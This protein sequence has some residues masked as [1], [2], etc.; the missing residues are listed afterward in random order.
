MA[1]GG[2]I[3]EFLVGLGWKIDTAGQRRFNKG[4]ND[5]GKTVE[6]LGSSLKLITEIL[7]S[8]YEKMGDVTA[9]AYHFRQELNGLNKETDGAARVT[10]RASVSWSEARANIIAY[11]AGA[12]ASV[13]AIVAYTAKT[14]QSYEALEY[15]SQRAQST[16]AGM[17]K[18][19]FA[20]SEMGGNAD[21]ARGSLQAMGNFLR[22]TP[23][24]E[25]FIQRLGVQT[26][27][28]AGAMRDTS[29]IMTDLGKQ[30]RNMPYWRARA[31]AGMLGIDENTLQAMIRGTSD[32][33]SKYAAIYK[34]LGI[35]QN[36]AAKASTRFMQ[37]FRLMGAV[38]T[39]VRDKLAIGLEPVIER[40]I[41]LLYQFEEWV[42]RLDGSTKGWI[43]GIS[44]FIV[45]WLVMNTAI[46]RSPIGRV[47]ALGLAIAALYDDYKT[48]QAG[49]KSL[50]N[51]KEWAPGID[52]AI[53]AISQIK[54][55]LGDMWTDTAPYLKPM[56]DFIKHEMID[57]FLSLGRVVGSVA[58]SIDKMLH[59]NFGGAWSDLK[60][61]YSE[62]QRSG[63][64]A[65]N[66]GGEVAKG[67]LPRGLRNNNPGNIR[68]W[69]GAGSDGQFA[70]FKSPDEGIS[71]AV[72]NIRA[73]INKHGIDTIRG[74]IS[75][76]APSS[77]GNN[78]DAYIQHVSQRTHIDPDAHISPNDAESIGRIVDAITMSENSGLN[79][80]REKDYSIAKAIVGN[81]N[82]ARAATNSASAFSGA[83][84]SDAEADALRNTYTGSQSSA[85]TVNQTVT[86]NGATNPQSVADSVVRVTHGAVN[87]AYR[88]FAPRRQ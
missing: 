37:Q 8:M 50:I 48:W 7:I 5:A 33:G 20:I 53:D 73:Y 39:A 6:G 57:A 79:P 43:A 81:S 15:A 21:A 24:G 87:T 35:D 27:D 51:W 65:I 31:S 1:D 88:N 36:Q 11:A 29:S 9:E 34:R 64:E 85:P 69:A 54:T 63:Q 28:A 25:G 14:A 70:V 62:L 17:Q 3:K 45:V 12:A 55:L 56:A 46:M 71:A 26:R 77:D 68:Q 80:W 13:T 49:G 16:V 67:L 84:R 41:D 82:I 72:N 86:I 18:F 74:I 40:G 32:F 60:D 44:A 75:R 2:V 61:V 58:K 42:H 52:A 66:Y 19:A 47:I 78:T 22:S 59:G 30:F 4:I 23:G 38:I 10:K 83:G 76:W